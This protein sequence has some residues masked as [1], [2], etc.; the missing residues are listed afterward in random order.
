MR[1]MIIA[2][3]FGFPG[4]MTI[5]QEEPAEISPNK[6]IIGVSYGVQVIDKEEIKET[7]TWEEEEEEYGIPEGE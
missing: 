3:A 2:L 1:S 6:P 4:I 5:S 7:T